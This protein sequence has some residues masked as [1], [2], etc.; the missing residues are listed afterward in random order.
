MLK[1]LS[2]LIIFLVANKVV[3]QD[4]SRLTIQTPTAAALGRYE[5]VPVDESTGVPQISIPLF[6]FHVGDVEFP[7]TPS[8]H[9]GGVKVDQLESQVGLSWS[10]LGFP[11]MSR[12]IRGIPDENSRGRC[13][14]DIPDVRFILTNKIGLSYDYIKL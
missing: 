14:S 9:A 7:V 8:Y 12:N 5:T 1:Y 10:L 6:S 13:L 4:L 11:N 3:A 2:Y